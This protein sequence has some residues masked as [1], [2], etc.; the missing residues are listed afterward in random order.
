[1]AFI[2]SRS[3]GASAPMFVRISRITLCY[4]IDYFCFYLGIKFILFK[5]SY[6]VNNNGVNME[7]FEKLKQN[8]PEIAKIVATFPPQLQEKVYDNLVSELLGKKNELAQKEPKQDI[9]TQTP[10]APAGENLSAIATLTPEGQYHSS[11]RDLKAINAKD[12][13]KRLVY[14]LIQSYTKLMNSSSVSRKEI[15]NPELI[16]WRL[17]DGNTRALIASDRGIIK[18]GDQL[19]LDQHA[20]NEADQFINDIKDSEKVGTWKPGIIK[21]QKRKKNESEPNDDASPEMNT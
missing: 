5:I 12:A 2:A 19:S 11:I 8:L 15:I 14:T 4:V 13:A 1:M 21:K 9:I 6:N 17:S 3:T 18:I 10:Q 7:H 20:Q 16:R